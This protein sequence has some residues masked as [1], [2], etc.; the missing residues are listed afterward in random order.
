MM[1]KV[2][3][4]I[5]DALSGGSVYQNRWMRMHRIPPIPSTG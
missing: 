1:W 5:I 3:A 4:Y 2:Y